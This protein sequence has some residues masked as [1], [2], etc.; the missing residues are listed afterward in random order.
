[1]KPSSSAH[2]WSMAAT[3]A[4]RRASSGSAVSA[5][6]FSC[7]RRPP[8]TLMSLSAVAEDMRVRTLVCREVPPVPRPRGGGR[9]AHSLGGLH[10]RVLPELALPPL[11]LEHAI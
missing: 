6:S 3:A 9:D 8:W 1:M 5:L 11:E 2:H 10:E 7:T 4:T